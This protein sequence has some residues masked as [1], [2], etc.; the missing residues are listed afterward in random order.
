MP[1]SIF[2]L[3][4]KTLNPKPSTPE[5][6]AGAKWKLPA[7]VSGTHRG[8]SQLAA[9]SSS[10][11]ELCQVEGEIASIENLHAEWEVRGDMTSICLR[12]YIYIYICISPVGFKGNLSLLEICLFVPGILTKWKMK[13]PMLRYETHFLGPQ[14]GALLTV[15]FLVGR[16]PLL[17]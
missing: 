16:V 1:F 17:K 14:L 8:S 3:A 11:R 2:N 10:A 15:S 5:L 12:I 6:L 9:R 13:A 7:L 4:P